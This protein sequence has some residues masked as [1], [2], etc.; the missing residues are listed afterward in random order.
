MNFFEDLTQTGLTC[1]PTKLIR[2]KKKNEAGRG[3]E[4]LLYDS[5]TFPYKHTI[6]FIQIVGTVGRMPYLST[7]HHIYN[8]IVLAPG[9][10]V[11]VLE[12]TMEQRHQRI[13][14]AQ[15]PVKLGS[16]LYFVVQIEHAENTT[17]Q[18]EGNERAAAGSDVKDMELRRTKKGC[19]LDAAF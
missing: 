2:Y 1:P 3:F 16:G 6:A 13:A 8:I 11:P 12:Q 9:V 14:A 18:K 10:F 15:L 17:G 7:L 5:R 19:I 4:K